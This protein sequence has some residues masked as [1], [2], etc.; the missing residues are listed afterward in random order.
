MEAAAR[1]L[2]VAIGHDAGVGPEPSQGHCFLC[3][4]EGVLV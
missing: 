2:A 1:R 4:L 3:D